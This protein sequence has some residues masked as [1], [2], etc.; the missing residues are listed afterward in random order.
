MT[1]YS[2]PLALHWFGAAFALDYTNMEQME[3]EIPKKTPDKVHVPLGWQV[4]SLNLP[5][6]RVK[7][8]F[9]PPQMAGQTLKTEKY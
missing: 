6:G 2:L 1:V 3:K 8:S 4:F 5:L 9:K 7:Q